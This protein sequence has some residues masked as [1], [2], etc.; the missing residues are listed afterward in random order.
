M[1][2]RDDLLRRM[3][4]EIDFHAAS[5]AGLNER[6]RLFESTL[7]PEA[8]FSSESSLG[9]YQSSIESL[10]TLLRARITEF[11]LQLEYVRL[12]AETIKTNARLLY[13]QGE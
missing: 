1:Y 12:Q 7:L 4:S 8:E 3:S 6:M 9:A 2:S 5:L 13:L 10:T 11:D